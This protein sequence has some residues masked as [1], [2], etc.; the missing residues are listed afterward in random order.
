MGGILSTE[1]FD[2]AL[3][4]I[5]LDLHLGGREAAPRDVAAKILATLPILE[6]LDTR[7]MEWVGLPQTSGQRS[8][9]DEL[10]PDIEELIH[11]VNAGARRDDAGSFHPSWGYFVQLVAYVKGT[12]RRTSPFHAAISDGAQ[13]GPSSDSF[14]LTFGNAL[15][16]GK[17]A[18]VSSFASLVEVWRPTHG[19]IFGYE[20]SRR[21]RGEAVWYP[22]VGALTY[23]AK[24][25]GYRLPVHELVELHP[26][27]HGVLA[28]LKEWSLDAVLTYG[29]AFRAV[30]HGVPRGNARTGK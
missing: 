22:P 16:F 11:L 9:E 12:E 14:S 2:S 24:A 7:P 13:G 29:E 30:N 20:V 1:L 25:S 27:P 5:D 19:G 18:L 15:I 17:G 26:L 28:V 21:R 10:G 3:D 4:D 23:T 6:Q 8:G